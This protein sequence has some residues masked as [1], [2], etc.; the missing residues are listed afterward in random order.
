[1]YFR[2]CYYILVKD[3][4]VFNFCLKNYRK[5]KFKSFRRIV[6]EEEILK[7]FSIDCGM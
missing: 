4:I 7:Y 1:M 6:F 2:D 5:V 3:V